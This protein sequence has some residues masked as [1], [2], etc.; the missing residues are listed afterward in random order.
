[1]P[2]KKIQTLHKD[3]T[4]WL[5]ELDFIQD[6]LQCFKNELLI[7]CAD[8]HM[9]EVETDDILIEIEGFMKNIAEARYGIHLH[10]NYLAEEAAKG[11]RLDFDHCLEEEKLNTLFDRYKDFKLRNRN[12]T[13]NLLRILHENVN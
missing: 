8:P 6:E 3:H 4:L 11:R 7:I 5:Q 13:S 9:K 10:E 12:A 2:V 1:M